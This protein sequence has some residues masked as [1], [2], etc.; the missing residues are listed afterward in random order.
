MG[1]VALVYGSTEDRAFTLALE[2]LLIALFPGVTC[3]TTNTRQTADGP[4][5]LG[6][7]IAGDGH[8]GAWDHAEVAFQITFPRS[9]ASLGAANAP[10]GIPQFSGLD[11]A[12][13]EDLLGRIAQVLRPQAPI[14]LA[15]QRGLLDELA[16]LGDARAGSPRKRARLRQVLLLGLVCAAAAAGLVAWMRAMREVVRL[17]FE[18]EERGWKLG[19]VTEGTGARSM[20]RTAV[21]AKNGKYAVQLELQL[22]PSQGA[23]S[24]GEAWV[25]LRERGALDLDRRTVS[26]WVRMYDAPGESGY[27]LFVKDAEWHACYGAWQPASREWQRVSVRVGDAADDQYRD[28][29]FDAKNV[30]AIGVKVGLASGA[31]RGFSGSALLDSIAW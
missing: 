7:W 22:E 17:G 31:Q 30:I 5:D 27:Q 9:D 21:A 13:L 14:T 4:Y 10:R 18:D 16:Q 2:R 26:A 3:V 6:I 24:S 11:P 20:S 29:Q 25:D 19:S 1:A 8:H 15:S 12:Q 23:R 28:P